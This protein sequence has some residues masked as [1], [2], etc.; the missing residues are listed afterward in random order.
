[1]THIVWFFGGFLVAIIIS[2][3]LWYRKHRRQKKR[4]FQMISYLELTVYGKSCV[5]API[6]DEFSLLEDELSKTVGEL[7]IARELSQKEREQQADNLADIAHQLKTPLTSMSLMTQL[8]EEHAI[9]E[10]EEYLQRMT[11][12]L[13]RLEWLTSSLLTMSR[14]EASAIEFLK[15]ELLFEVLA[16]GSSEP[17]EQIMLERNQ[18]LIVSGEDNM[19]VC[20]LHWTTEALLNLLKNCSEHTPLGGEIYL[21]YRVTPLHYEIIVEDSGTGFEKEEIPR[22]FQ[23]FYKGINAKKDSIG[24][25]LALSKAMIEGQGGIIRAENRKECGARFIIGFY[26]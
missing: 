14:L 9:P 6:Q 8:M 15:T 1:M 5:L 4:L 18:T 12:Q 13:I 26:F 21:S 25:G 17:M 11:N 23:R 3:F 7:R 19:I 20:D 2:S 24:I 10:Q 16:T 22:L